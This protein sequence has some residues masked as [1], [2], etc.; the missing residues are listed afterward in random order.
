M[1]AVDQRGLS[2][3]PPP[4]GDANGAGAVDIGAYERQATETREVFNGFNS[5]VDIVDV[6]ITFP[7]VLPCEEALNSGNAKRHSEVAPAVGSPTASL[8]ID[9]RGS[10]R[11]RDLVIARS[12]QCTGG[13]FGLDSPPATCLLP[14]ISDPRSL[15]A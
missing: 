12:I 14:A 1:V 3:T 10:S 2:R 9:Q 15:Q 13:R 6:I 11:V 8:S 4:D 5:S 7:C